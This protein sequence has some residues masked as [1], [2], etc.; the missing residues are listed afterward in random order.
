MDGATRGN[1]SDCGKEDVEKF[2][3]EAAKRVVKFEEKFPKEK[4]YKN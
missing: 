3:V 2:L 4:A 1:T